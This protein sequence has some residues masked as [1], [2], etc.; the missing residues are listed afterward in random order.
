MLRSLRNA[1]FTGLVLVLPLGITLI[2]LNFLL[3]KLGTRASHV[4]FG[5]LDRDFRTLPAVEISLQIIS[6]LVVITLITSLGYFSR[7]V[8]GRMILSTME[9]I[10]DRVPFINSVYRT[11]KQIVD[12][13][14]QQDKAIFQQ[15]VLV[16]Y[17]RRKCYAVGFLTSTGGGEVQAVTHEHILNVFIPT[18]PNPTSGYLLMLPEEDVQPLEMS[19]TDGMKLI[20]SGGAV[21]PPY[22]GNKAVIVENPTGTDGLPLEEAQKKPRSAPPIDPETKA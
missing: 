21:V 14:S 4:F 8:F 11:V 7:F 6:S 22:S 9:R 17:P 1:F 20:I 13:F 10:L 18:T 5:F 19:V 15:V 3:D 2:F 16:E 12:T